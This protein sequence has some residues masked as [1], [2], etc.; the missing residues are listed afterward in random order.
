MRYI[1]RELI[2]TLL[3]RSFR[4]CSSYEN[5]HWKIETLNPIFQHIDSPQNFMKQC[6]K[7]FLDKLIIKIT[8]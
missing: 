2:E 1:K 8:P 4:L 5:F 3:H 7:M 6:I